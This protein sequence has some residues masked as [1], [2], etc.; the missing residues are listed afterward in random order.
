MSAE[1]ALAERL[2]DALHRNLPPELLTLLTSQEPRRGLVFVRKPHS[3]VSKDDLELNS[4]LVNA[5][6]DIFPEHVPSKYTLARAV[7]A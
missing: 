6:L 5:A 2:G 7:I 1:E 3:G 4:A